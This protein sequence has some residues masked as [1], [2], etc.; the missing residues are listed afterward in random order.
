MNASTY[1][2]N[3]PDALEQKLSLTSSGDDG[4][5]DDF[6]SFESKEALHA[7]TNSTE[8]IIGKSSSFPD[9]ATRSPNEKH[10]SMEASKKEFSRKEAVE[11]FQTPHVDPSNIYPISSQ[12]IS[13][14]NERDLQ[15]V[16]TQ[17]NTEF[18][19]SSM[20]Q[21][22]TQT[23]F[24]NY[25]LSAVRQQPNVETIP[26]KES[27]INILSKTYEENSQES[28]SSFD[29]NCDIVESLLDSSRSPNSMISFLENHTT[30]VSSQPNDGLKQIDEEPHDTLSE[31]IVVSEDLR[32]SSNTAMDTDYSEIVRHGE[33]IEKEYAMLKHSDR[34]I[35][36]DDKNQ[37]VNDHEDYLT[38][39][40]NEEPSDKDQDDGI[41]NDDTSHRNTM[42]VPQHVD[43]NSGFE[44]EDKLLSDWREDGL[45]N[46]NDF[47]YKDCYGIIH[48]RILRS[49]RLSCPVYSDVHAIVS[50]PPW[51]GR[52]RSK[53][54][55]A[56]S[57]PDAS[58]GS[59]DGDKNM[60]GSAIHSGVC[61][62][63]DEDRVPSLSM[64]H[65]AMSS[66]ADT[67]QT[68]PS[69]KLELAFCP[70]GISFVEL[71]MCS[72]TV[73]CRRLLQNPNVS[74]RQWFLADSSADQNTSKATQTQKNLQTNEKQESEP[75][76]TKSSSYDDSMSIAS[77]HIDDSND[78]HHSLSYRFPIIEIEAMFE[79]L[80][81]SSSKDEGRD[82]P[83]LLGVD[84]EEQEYAK[85]KT[86]EQDHFISASRKNDSFSINADDNASYA[87]K[88]SIAEHRFPRTPLSPE[89]PTNVRGSASFSGDTGSVSTQ[90]FSK[91]E[92]SKKQH[93]FRTI[94]YWTPAV[95]CV[96]K[97][98]IMIG[99]WSSK[100][101]HCEECNIDCCMDCRLHVDIQLPCGSAAAAQARTD[102]IQSKL[103][104]ENI[105]S[106]VAP[107]VGV[108]PKSIEQH[109]QR[110]TANVNEF[111][112]IPSESDLT[113]QAKNI[114]SSNDI[115]RP[116]PDNQKNTN[117]GV[118]VMK[119]NFIRAHVLKNAMPLETEPSEI[120]NF[121]GENSAKFRSGDYYIRVTWT[122]SDKSA[123]T[124]TVQSSGGRPKFRANEMRFTV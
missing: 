36:E 95:C 40:Q 1:D 49:Q 77:I 54:T 80:D 112:S 30:T 21:S 38:Q 22:N 57:G 17:K 35:V 121:D 44:I 118:G 74:I 3:S 2:E 89:R 78:S 25:F 43:C 27:T 107:V 69:I 85:E 18:N 97:K 65:D 60:L 63:W 117:R 102:S 106:V 100:A 31:R 73:S 92:T 72:L 90:S 19:L 45:A 81:L 120:V 46:S 24:P 23:V 28:S 41:E 13:S 108:D 123:R 93:L 14:I 86:S 91:I 33:H 34:K 116:N 15:N 71:S 84:N 59:E 56:F 115:V 122:G 10:E 4:E 105:M 42:T 79:P 58:L 109:S 70:L 101:F 82:S 94:T 50:L 32:Q 62:V 103:T 52:I 12:A 51:T 8:R 39:S 68:V 113:P 119:L 67:A 48:V 53:A 76:I 98:N 61:A 111:L 99:L 6:L 66:D 47:N 88:L 16:N 87:T 124:Q 9:D 11:L 83:N 20:Q 104:V 75:L 55:K 5:S 64:I 96:C 114:S 37:E 110:I 26:S 29:D 7:R